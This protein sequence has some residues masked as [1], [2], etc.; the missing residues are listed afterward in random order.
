MLAVVGMPVRPAPSAPFKRLAAID[1]PFIEQY[2]VLI[3][4][5]PP[6][7]HDA[8][9]AASEQIAT[10]ADSAARTEA[11]TRAIDPERTDLHGHFIQALADE[12]G[13]AGVKTVLVQ[14][15]P[16]ESEAQLV[17]QARKAAPGADAILLAHVIGRFVAPPGVEDYLPGVMLGVKLRAAADDRVWLEDVYTTGYRGIDPSATHVAVDADDRYMGFASLVRDIGPARALLIRGV[18]Q[19]AIT[20]A[21]AVLG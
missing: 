3:A 16:V 6:L 10:T 20:V 11:L 8:V 12:L 2:E 5:A 15:D 4:M 14:L 13:P 19:I 7:A 1:P 17:A 21:R 9:G 18:E